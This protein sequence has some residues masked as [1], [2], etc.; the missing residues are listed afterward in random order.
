LH[1]TG[2]D[3][4]SES[5]LTH[6]MFRQ[7]STTEGRWITPDP[8]GLGA[9]DPNNP[10]T[11]NRY[12][13]VMNDPLGNA[14]P[15]GLSVTCD[16]DG[17]CHVVVWAPAPDPFSRREGG[18]ENHETPRCA[19]D[20]QWPCRVRLRLKLHL[21]LPAKN[22]VKQTICSALPQAR[23]TSVN[24]SAGLVGGQQGSAQQVVNY[25]NGEVSNFLTGGL[26]AGWNGGVSASA[27][28][29]FV[30]MSNG[31][32]R[33]SDFSGPFNNVSASAPEGPGGSVS[34]ASNGV[35]IVQGGVGVSLIPGPTGNYSYTWTSNPTPGGNIWT[36]LASPLGVF[37][38]T[39]Y[40]LRKAAGC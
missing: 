6:F 31:Q 11:W 12:A 23:V 13:Y 22:T 19:N 40:G 34:W 4:D 33:N 17:N 15:L 24:G 30:Y 7:L 26:Q 5:N 3:W 36:N 28:A 21:V 29:G 9:V 39:L 25:N 8:S 20:M 32:F 1:F 18:L 10:Q 27:S 38:L 35:K 2:Q 14:D 37:D 16:K